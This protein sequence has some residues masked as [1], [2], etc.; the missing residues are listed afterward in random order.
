MPSEV[1]LLN[2]VNAWVTHRGG[3]MGFGSHRVMGIGLPL[4]QALTVPELKA[5]IAHEFGHYHSGDVALGP[6]IYKTR[7]AIVRT[8]AGVR[9]TWFEHL[10]VWY[11]RLFL[12]VTH[13][14]SRQQ[15]FI[16]DAMAAKLCGPD[17][18]AGA[19]RRTAALGPMFS[20][21]VGQ[22]VVPV[23]NAGF[24]PPL[25]TGFDTFLQAE[26]MVLTSADILSEAE[27][28]AQADPFDTHPTLRERLDAL[29]VTEMSVPTTQDPA[30]RLVGNADQLGLSLIEHALG[31]EAS[32]QLKP[33]AW[34]QVGAHVYEP[35]F[36]S[37]AKEYAQLLS[38]FA[39]DTIPVDRDGFIRVGSELMHS[40]QEEA[41]IS[42]EYHVGRASFVLGAAIG[43]LLLDRGWHSDKLPGKPVVLVRG[44]ATVEPFATVRAIADGTLAVES[45][46]QQCVSLGIAGQQLGRSES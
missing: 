33:I 36:R 38:R 28:Q 19:L 37:V 35:H 7:S 45:W 41:D 30:L 22:E 2:E 8:V 18:M 17:A 39:A 16:A 26:R 43:A 23:L 6:W 14:V 40:D 34:Q 10:F 11:G 31:T 12:K 1:Y 20:T 32:N 44:D 3:V 9:D 13:A 29:A 25:A 4:L 15:E 21:Y 24:L 27:S 42:G 46:K 5:V